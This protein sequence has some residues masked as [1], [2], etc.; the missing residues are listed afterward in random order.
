MTEGV[1]HQNDGFSIVVDKTIASVIHQHLEDGNHIN[2]DYVIKDLGQQIAI[3]VKNLDMIAKLEW[4]DEK[5]LHFETIKLEAKKSNKTP[6]QEIVSRIEGLLLDNSLKISES[7]VSFLPKKW[8]IF[9]DLAILP[10]GTLESKEWYD[11]CSK[12][13]SLSKEIWHIIADS[14]KVSRIARQSEIAKDK[15]RSSQVKMIV[16]DSGEVEFVDNGVKFW[17]DVTKVMFSSGNVTERHRIGDIDMTGEI[18]V[19]AFSGIGYYSLPML[20]RSNA[21]HVYACE[22]NPNSI[23]ALVK[24]A[25]LNDVTDRLTIIE[26]DNQITLQSLTDIADRVHLGIL[27]SSENTWPLAIDCLKQ[28]GGII[29]IH[30]NVKEIEI[31]SFVNYC[32][33]QL[34]QYAEHR[35]F[36][37]IQLE[38][39]EKVK[40]YA[41][42]IRHIVIDVSIE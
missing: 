40:W 3:P 35:G 37:K 17:L 27:P 11:I 23:D 21:K 32:L 19:D 14:L 42:H 5:I 10:S 30:M 41:P 8:E 24:G 18:V 16:G 7:M 1:N 33:E 26:G 25:E 34:K 20:V 2:N 36:K 39:V 6:A 4:F 38:H 15:L 12:N 9:N 22:L 13:K 29:H 28:S 31:D